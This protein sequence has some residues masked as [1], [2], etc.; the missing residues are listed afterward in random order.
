MK[1]AIAVNGARWK[2]W[3]TKRVRLHS[4]PNPDKNDERT[5]LWVSDKN[6]T[7]RFGWV[8]LPLFGYWIVKE[9]ED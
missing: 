1:H 4:V 8:G 5:E 9:W 3:K 6:P 7:L 2:F